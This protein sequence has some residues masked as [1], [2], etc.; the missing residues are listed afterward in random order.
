MVD[1]QRYAKECVEEEVDGSFPKIQF[2]LWFFFIKSSFFLE[3]RFLPN[4]ESAKKIERAQLGK[5]HAVC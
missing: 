2:S 3:S 5:Q 1:N 4:G